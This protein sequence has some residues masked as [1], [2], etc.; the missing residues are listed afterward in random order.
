MNRTKN[1]RSEFGKGEIID[2]ILLGEKE[3]WADDLCRA[4]KDTVIMGGDSE[5]FAICHWPIVIKVK[6]NVTH[7][8]LKRSLRDYLDYLDFIEKHKLQDL[9][10]KRNKL[11]REISTLKKANLKN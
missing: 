1:Q 8:L 10:N 4:Y 6:K 9:Q 7:E 5:D 2:L 11:N 3:K